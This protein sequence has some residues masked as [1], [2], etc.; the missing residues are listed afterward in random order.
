MPVSLCIHLS[1]LV[2]RPIPRPHSLLRL[3]FPGSEC[4]AQTNKA[5]A[6]QMA[7]MRVP[8]ASIYRASQTLPTFPA[9]PANSSVE[10]HFK[11]RQ[12]LVF[13]GASW[14]PSLHQPGSIV[15][16]TEMAKTQ[17]RSRGQGTRTRKLLNNPRAGSVLI[18][19][20]AAPLQTD[21]RCAKISRKQV[22]ATLSSC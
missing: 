9:V 1:A 6:A 2:Y 15:S 7:G 4:T 21:E 17:K 18:S 14:F 16:V 11:A 22:V 20:R 5:C 10:N 13:W 19:P 8:A 12:Q 3:N